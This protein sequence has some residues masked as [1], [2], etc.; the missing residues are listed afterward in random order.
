VADDAQPLETLRGPERPRTSA[1]VRLAGIG[2]V[3]ALAAVAARHVDLRAVVRT[4]AGADP[5]LVAL[6]CG[7]N[8]LSLALHSRRWAAVVRPPSVRIRFRD[9]FWPVVAGFAAGL[10]VPARAGDV[11]RAWMLA[12]RTGLST[13][14]VVAASALDYLIG[15][16]TLIPVL[17][18]VALGTPL[19]AWARHVLLVFA[20][21]AA[22]GAIAVRFLRPPRDRPPPAPGTGGLITRLRG[23]LAAAHHPHAIATAVAWGLGGWCAEI[24]IALFTLAALG[25]PTSFPVAAFAVVATT[26]ANI[27]VVSPGNAGPFELAAVLALASVG[28]DRAPALAFALLYHLVHLV[29]VAVLGAW[30]ALRDAAGRRAA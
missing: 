17:A 22:L 7:A 30:V 27:V 8:V 29:P 18:L 6:A 23:G 15:A 14:T 20:L 4:L 28:V 26:A 16:A 5:W 13:A 3:V 2:V 25:L 12:R 1:A 21:V 19:P 9:A 24:L 11:L 10:V